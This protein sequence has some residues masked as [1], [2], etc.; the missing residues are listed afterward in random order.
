MTTIRIEIVG[1]DRA[2]SGFGQL[3]EK[4]TKLKPLMQRFAKEFYSEEKSLFDAAPWKPLSPAYAERKRKKYGD[5]PILRA[6][7]RL[8]RSLTEEGTE[9][10]IHRIRDDGADLGSGVPYGIFHQYSRP[11]IAEPDEGKYTSLAEE[12]VREMIKQSGFN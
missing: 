12:Y 3:D 9:G 2:L 10:N 7:D 6:T 4:L 1:L 11:P 8:W 5:K